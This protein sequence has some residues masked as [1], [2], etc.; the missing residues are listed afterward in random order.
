MRIYE[1]TY[2][3]LNVYGEELFCK[4]RT[5]SDKGKALKALQA[6]TEDFVDTLNEFLYPERVNLYTRL[7][8]RE[9]TNGE[10]KRVGSAVYSYSE[11]V[12][13]N[14]HKDRDKRHE[15]IN[16]DLEFFKNA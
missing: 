3:G 15:N 4:G 6:Y 12:N 1:V 16:A 8:V 10:F 9:E 7:K 13:P 5:F 2:F 14:S 11:G